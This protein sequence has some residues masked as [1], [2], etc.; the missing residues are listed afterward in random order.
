MKSVLGI[1]AA[2]IM[3][4]GACTAG[5]KF[6]AAM[7]TGPILLYAQCVVGIHGLLIISKGKSWTLAA[8]NWDS[9]TATRVLR[10]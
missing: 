4:A 2:W 1:H 3:V 10:K 8:S 6:R 7:M 5:A 9:A